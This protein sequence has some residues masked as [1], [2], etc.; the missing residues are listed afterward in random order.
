MLETTIKVLDIEEESKE[1]QLF[2]ENRINFV[3]LSDIIPIVY[4]SFKVWLFRFIVVS[5][6]YTVIIKVLDRFFFFQ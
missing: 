4:S 5:F 3:S 6:M 2:D 1:D